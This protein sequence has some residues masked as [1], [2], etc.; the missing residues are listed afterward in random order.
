MTEAILTFQREKTIFWS[1]LAVL[2]VCTVFYIYFVTSTI[3]TAVAVEDLETN[4]NELVLAL[5]QKEFDVINL[6][7]NVSLNYA[8]SRGFVPVASQTYITKK[9]VGF[10]PSAHNE[11]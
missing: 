6:K 5:G 2:G 4:V 11:I 8:Q 7:N 3:R 10:L 9:S 1:L